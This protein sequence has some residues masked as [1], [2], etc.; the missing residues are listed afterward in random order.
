MNHGSVTRPACA[1]GCLNCGRYR[2]TNK[3]L[4]F[5]LAR[6]GYYVSLKPLEPESSDE[7]TLAPDAP[8][9]TAAAVADPAVPVPTADSATTSRRRRGRPCKCV[10]RGITCKHRGAGQVN[11][12]IPQP[13]PRGEFS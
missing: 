13:C 7:T 9:P 12:L 4:P 11:S 3:I 5:P 10:E 6:L 1:R 2:P 8:I